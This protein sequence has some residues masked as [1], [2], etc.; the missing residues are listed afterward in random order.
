MKWRRG[1]GGTSRLEEED[2][3]REGRYLS[4][5][6]V[7]YYYSVLCMYVP[8]SDAVLSP[9]PTHPASQVPPSVG[10][11]VSG[12]R[13]HLTGTQVGVHLRLAPINTA[14]RSRTRP[15]EVLAGHRCSRVAVKGEESE[16]KKKAAS[17]NS[18]SSR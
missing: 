8:A 6:A 10:L 2:A 17:G 1:G 3:G 7:Y 16:K 14:S 4:T 11:Q 12:T 5:T 18:S 9:P 13:E 15:V